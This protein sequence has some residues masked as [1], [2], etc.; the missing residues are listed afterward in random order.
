ME[1]LKYKSNIQITQHFNSN[2]IRCP[3]CGII[4]I[5]PQLLDKLENLFNQLN[6]SK[7]IISSG[8]RCATY[9][10]LK[11]GFAGRHSEGL[12]IDCCFYDDENKMI[13]SKI[14]ICVAFDLKQFN[15]IAKIND[16]YTHL[17]IRTFGK[18]YG[19]ETIGISSY[20]TNPYSYF[21]VSTDDVKKYASSTNT[22]IHYQVHGLNKKWYSNVKKGSIPNYAGVFGVPIDGLYI[23]NLIYRVRINGRWLP[24]VRGR[25]DYAGILGV[26]ITDIAIKDAV[27]RVHLKESNKWLKWVSGYD[28]NEF[29]NGYAGNGSIIDAI[30]IK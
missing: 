28:I 22:R 23:D 8:Y 14:V 5:A 25:E 20:W 11:N 30:Q 7:C 2:E 27:Y 21:N 29:Y 13:P 18:Y 19:D 15:G 17:D 4:K 26:P 3:H 1:V 16:Y 12:A 10:K 6:A 24:E 9:D